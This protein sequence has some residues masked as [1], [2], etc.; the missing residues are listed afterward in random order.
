MKT[1]KIIVGILVGIIALGIIFT[2]ILPQSF[3]ATPEPHITQTQPQTTPRNDV[4]DQTAVNAST[5][6]QLQQ[7]FSKDIND[8]I[9]LNSPTKDSI[10]S[11]PITVTGKAQWKLVFWRNISSWTHRW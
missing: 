3:Y 2:L 10:V 1:K 11:S 7:N 6:W 8:L 5:T 9:I 4:A